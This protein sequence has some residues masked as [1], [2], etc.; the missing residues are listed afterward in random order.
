[1]PS[2]DLDPEGLPDDSVP[3][4]LAAEGSLAQVAVQ[5][6]EEEPPDH[7][8]WPL[9]GVTLASVLDLPSRF[10]CCVREP[11]SLGLSSAGGKK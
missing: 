9:G 2:R 7:A 11:A 1:M 8:Y 5:A 10:R 3:G 4:D 6:G